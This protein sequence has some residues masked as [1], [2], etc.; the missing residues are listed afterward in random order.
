MEQL[1]ESEGMNI[2]KVISPDN[3]SLKKKENVL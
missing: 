2:D 3:F 1:R